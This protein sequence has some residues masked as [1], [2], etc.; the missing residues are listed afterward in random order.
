MLRLVLGT[1]DQQKTAPGTEESWKA[2]SHNGNDSSRADGD[3]S[4]EASAFLPVGSAFFGAMSRQSSLAC[5]TQQ[6]QLLVTA[7]ISST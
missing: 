3:S 4:R 7:N 5:H 2:S 6:P 1:A